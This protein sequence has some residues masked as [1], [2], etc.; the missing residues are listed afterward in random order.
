MMDANTHAQSGHS[1][2]YSIIR[3]MYARMRNVGGG[4]INTSVLPLPSSWSP[5]FKLPLPFPRAA[6]HVVEVYNGVSLSV[7]MLGRDACRV[8]KYLGALERM[9]FLCKGN[10]GSNMLTSLSV[11]K[12]AIETHTQKNAF[13]ASCGRLCTLKLSTVITLQ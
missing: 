11:E 13:H 4:A 7:S 6:S 12:H 1:Q 3:A 10:M 9:L 8:Q 5:F 2:D